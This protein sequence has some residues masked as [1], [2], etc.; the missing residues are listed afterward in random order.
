MLRHNAATR[1]AG[2]SHAACDG[3]IWQRKNFSLA[4]WIINGL[5]NLDLINFI[6]YASL[7]DWN[8]EANLFWTH[9]D[10]IVATLS[11]AIQKHGLCGRCANG[12]ITWG[13]QE[14]NCWSYQDRQLPLHLCSG[15]FALANLVAV[16][17]YKLHDER[18]LFLSH[19]LLRK[20]ISL[21]WSNSLHVNFYGIHRLEH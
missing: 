5:F 10:Y 9:S 11:Q 6:V 21:L 7:E 18:L 19:W 4:F 14:A 12:M 17:G 8:M 13:L 2:T 3:L 15:R 16:A 1:G 20:L